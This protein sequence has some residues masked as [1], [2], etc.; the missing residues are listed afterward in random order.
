MLFHSGFM[1]QK[2]A[3]TVKTKPL[4][5]LPV[6]ELMTEVSSL[7]CSPVSQPIINKPMI[8]ITNHKKGIESA[9]TSDHFASSTN[10]LLNKIKIHREK[11]TK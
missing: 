8:S 2:R 9:M 11:L 6:M 4:N 1:I 3:I 10:T 5:W 7:L